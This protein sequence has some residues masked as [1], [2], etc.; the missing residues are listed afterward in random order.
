[1]PPRPKA[2]VASLTVA[3]AL[4]LA[5]A[6]CGSSSG[7]SDK[8]S[9]P[10]TVTFWHTATGPGADALTSLVSKFNAAHKGKI[11]VKPSF[12]G[13]Y[14]DAQ[15]KYTAAVQSSSTPSVIMMNDISTGFMS[16]SGQTV[17]VAKFSSKDTSFKMSDI[18][19]GVQKYYGDGSGGLLSMPFA[20]SEPV[21]YLNAQLVKQAG[22]DPKNPPTT[23]AQVAQWAQQIKDRTKKYGMS[24]NMSDSWILEELTAS[25]GDNFCTPDNGRG[26]TPATGVTMTSPTQT[27]F[28]TALQ[29]LFRDGSAL[30]PGTSPTAMADNFNAGKVG[31]L[32]T[33]SGSYTG[34]TNGPDVTVDVAPFPK[35]S[36]SPD[37]G[38]VIGGASL[39]I[40]GPGHSGAEQQAAYE[41]AK[42]LESAQS[43]A[44]WSKATG[45]LAANNAAKQTPDGEAT[46]KD[47]NVKTMYT[48]LTD[49]PGSA[50]SSGCRT[51]AYPAV[52][53]AIINGFN[54]AISGTP[55]ASAMKSAEQQADQQM[56][57][58]NASAK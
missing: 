52:R 12:Q 45:Y 13:T 36:G 14:A 39:W 28:L 31:M 35:T 20:V 11:E 26:S 27:A 10:V 56:S 32:L 58:Y 6:G 25:G 15:T 23:L 43:Q 7:S 16:D 42:F 9:G 53:T 38:T 22:L 2:L 50:A 37:A 48:Q 29:T 19:V 54:K 30:N 1:M 47:P 18:P 41:F 44:A 24:M 4:T 51:G 8:G 49:N 55:V 57:Q 46:L 5:L 40:D 34:F 3:T 21:L 33:S 17:P